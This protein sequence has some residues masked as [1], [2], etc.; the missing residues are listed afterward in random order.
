MAHNPPV[1]S[2]RQHHDDAEFN[3]CK[4]D[5]LCFE[6][7]D[8]VGLQKDPPDSIRRKIICRRCQKPYAWWYIKHYRPQY[9]DSESQYLQPNLR[10]EIIGV[11]AYFREK[12]ARANGEA[13][14]LRLDLE[15]VNTEND[16]LKQSNAEK[17]VKLNEMME[18][19]RE[20]QQIIDE[21]KVK[22]KE[23]KKDLQSELETTKP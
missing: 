15:R 2:K 16:N 23:L 17:D 21:V 14:R 4:A 22:V 18:V 9:A 19:V 3:N 11:E 12:V 5:N 7:N 20:Q 6:W 1:G 8:G 10:A 13:S